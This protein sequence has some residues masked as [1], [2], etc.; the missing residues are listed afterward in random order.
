MTSGSL[1]ATA[2]SD[3]TSAA[4]ELVRKPVKRNG[5]WFKTLSVTTPPRSLRFT[6]CT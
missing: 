1:Q 2:P 5:A 6:T 4:D 3:D